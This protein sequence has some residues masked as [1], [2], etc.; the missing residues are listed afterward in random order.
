MQGSGLDGLQGSG[1]VVLHGGGGHGGG[2]HGGLVL[3]GGGGH[4]GLGLHGSG[5]HGGRCP[6]H[7]PFTLC[8]SWPKI[9]WEPASD[10]WRLLPWDVLP[11]R[12]A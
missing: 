6:P 5:G 1:G 10:E 2:G 8:L 3:H 7:H 11:S 4:G 12:R 9:P